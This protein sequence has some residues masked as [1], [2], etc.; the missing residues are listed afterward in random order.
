MVDTPD[1]GLLFPD[2]LTLTRRIDS[3]S[4]ALS[5]NSRTVLGSHQFI[6]RYVAHLGFL[7]G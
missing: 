6:Y 4:G 2:V 5:F 1:N 3:A 7:I